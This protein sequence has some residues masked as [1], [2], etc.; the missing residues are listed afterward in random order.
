MTSFDQ[1]DTRVNK[2]CK[3]NASNKRETQY[4]KGVTVLAYPVYIS[5]L[6]KIVGPIYLQSP[7]YGSMKKLTVTYKELN[8]YR[9]KRLKF[10]TP[11]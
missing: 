1:N 3:Y 10:E 9:P 6:I 4:R 8:T 2:T 11:F 7:N 5:S